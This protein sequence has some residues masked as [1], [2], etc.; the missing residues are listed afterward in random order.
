[1]KKR[2]EKGRW[3]FCLAIGV[4]VTVFLASASRTVLAQAKYPSRPINFVCGFAAG[5]GADAWVRATAKVMG[6]ILKVDTSATS[7]PGADGLI[8]LQNIMKNVPADGYT[9]S[10]IEVSTVLSRARG[11]AGPDMRSPSEVTL[12]G[13]GALESFFFG[14]RADSKY[15][16]FQ[17][18]VADCKARPGEVKVSLGANTGAVY[19]IAKQMR[20]MMGLDFKLVPLGGS[21]PQWIELI[22]GRIDLAIADYSMWQPYLGESVEMNKRLQLLALSGKKRHPAQPNIPIFR[23][24]GYDIT[25]PTY[26]GFAV[27]PETPKNIV[28]TLVT[29]FADTFKDPEYLDMLPK[30]GRQGMFYQSPEETL[31]MIKDHWRIAETVN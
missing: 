7:Q 18:F 9:L 3:I 29:A 10:H 13:S 2:F 11:M 27:R 26:H 12:I 16:T 8:Q 21:A 24:L 19:T 14:A 1:M 22:A 30:I 28:A 4:F 5:G 20:A 31:A 6:K 23:E 17:D 25:L 15:K